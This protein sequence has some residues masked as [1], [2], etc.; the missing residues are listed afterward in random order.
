MI[1][2]DADQ[3]VRSFASPLSLT[4]DLCY[5]LR[6]EEGGNA[7]FDAASVPGTA[8]V[9]ASAAHQKTAEQEVFILWNGILR[10]E[11]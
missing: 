8:V 5:T 2:R 6:A 10:M 7:G 11:A 4:A 9:P 3:S 1:C